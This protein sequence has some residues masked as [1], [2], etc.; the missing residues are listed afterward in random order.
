[1]E[2]EQAVSQVICKMPF[3]WL[4]IED[5]AEPHSMRESPWNP[6]SD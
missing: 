4:A 2:L 3:L 5:G 1:M 6:L